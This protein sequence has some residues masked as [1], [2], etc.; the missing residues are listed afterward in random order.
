MAVFKKTELE[1]EHE[2]DA[3]SRRHYLN[4]VLSVLH[5]HHYSTLYTQLAEDCGMLDGR[6]LLFECAEDAFLEVL[7]SYY[8]AKGIG[9]VADR[10]E[11]AQQ[12]FAAMGLGSMSVIYAGPDAGLVHLTRSHVDEGWIKKWGKR[13]EPVN[14]IG[15]GYVAALFSAVFGRSARSYTVSEGKSIVSGEELSELGVVAC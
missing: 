12:Y 1:L 13:A 9:K 11:I 14:Y 6:R 7:A 8:R 5:C 15:R 3:T 4:G 10:I 2:F